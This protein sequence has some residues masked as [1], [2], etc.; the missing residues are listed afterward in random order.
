MFDS[1]FRVKIE[2]SMYFMQGRFVFTRQSLRAVRVLFSPL[3]SGWVDTYLGGQ[4]VGRAAGKVCPGCISETVMYRK[5]ILGRHIGY[6]VK[7]SNIM[8]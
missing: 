6:G 8:V 2:T 1:C 7:V 4:P 3:L 5:F